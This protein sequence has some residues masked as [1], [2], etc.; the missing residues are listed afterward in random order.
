MSAGA[1]YL[2]VRRYRRWAAIAAAGFGHGWR[3]FWGTRRRAREGANR[4]PLT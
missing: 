1:P 4:E 3:G 2:R